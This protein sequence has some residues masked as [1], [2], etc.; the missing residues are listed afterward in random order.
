[1]KPTGTTLRILT[2]SLG[3]DVSI[4]SQSQVCALEDANN[5]FLTDADVH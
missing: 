3:A 4:L 5:T 2:S 1:M